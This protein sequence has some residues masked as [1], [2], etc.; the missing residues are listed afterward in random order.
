MN[1]P[2]CYVKC[3][4]LVLLHTNVHDL[5]RCAFSHVEFR[6]ARITVYCAKLP[7]SVSMT[8]RKKKQER[9]LS[10]R[11]NNFLCC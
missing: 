5:Y 8:I 10:V 3:V 11:I 9:D 1:A 6:A 7:S 4:L 2:Q